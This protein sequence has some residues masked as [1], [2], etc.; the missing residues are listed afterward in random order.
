[1]NQARPGLHRGD[2]HRTV[3]IG[4]TRR[5]EFEPFLRWL[6][7]QVTVVAEFAS[8]ESAVQ[9]AET[10]A[11]ADLILVLQAWSDQFRPDSVNQLIGLTLQRRLICC[12]GPFCES[13]GR[14]RDV[15]PDA[16]RVPQRLAAAL[17]ERELTDADAGRPAIPPTAGRDE[18]FA[19]RLG[20]PI[21]WAP[22][23]S[24]QT[25]NAAVISPDRTLRRTVAQALK[26]FGL[27][28]VDLP[29]IAAGD[30]GH[31]RQK[32][33][34]RGPVHVVI[35]DL[36]PFSQLVANSLDACR[37]MFPSATV[38]GLAAMADA[39]LA[40]ETA[41]LQL[42][43]MIPKLDMEYGLRWQL[44]QLLNRN[45]PTTTATNQNPET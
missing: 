31:V 11:G 5:R 15:W 1:M 36:D 39:G 26:S 24:E 3:L 28:S 17:I 10:L 7:T 6:R 43:G 2:H 32:E 45:Y 41:D 29:L 8:I 40:I 37:R 19:H 27:G 30:T 16:V 22:L 23:T 12:Y 42:D 20:Q 38:L 33:T 21:H 18:V 13:D 14:N 4:S 34:S 44:K 25:V 9:T 35:H